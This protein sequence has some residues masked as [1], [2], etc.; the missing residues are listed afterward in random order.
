M[1]PEG[2]GLTSDVQMFYPPGDPFDLIF[3]VLPDWAPSVIMDVGANVGQ[4]ASIYASSFPDALIHAFE[5]SPKAFSKLALVVRRYPNVVPHRLALG[6][7]EG[8]RSLTQGGRSA[9]NRLVPEGEPVPGNA[10]EVEVRSGADVM[11]SLGLD[12]VDFLKVDTEGHDL[13]VLHGFLPVIDR[14]DF[15][16]VEAAMNP[17][18]T[19]HVPFADLD[20][21][22]RG[23][24]FHLGFFFEQKPEWR[25]GAELLLRRCNPLYVNQRLLTLPENS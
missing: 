4:S 15:V 20:G 11:G 25:S 12:R 21:F 13:D 22:L 24:G 17:F 6:R 19:L 9:M 3:R 16:E 2:S 1:M 14:I 18:N 7:C 5:P 23:A 10:V 8:R